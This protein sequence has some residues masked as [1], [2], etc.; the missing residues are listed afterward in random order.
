MWGL[1]I[2]RPAWAQALIGRIRLKDSH[3][4]EEKMNKYIGGK[5]G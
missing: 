1:R 4:I 3:R 5:Y 2:R